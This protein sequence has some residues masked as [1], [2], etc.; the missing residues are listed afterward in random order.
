MPVW[1]RVYFPTLILPVILNTEFTHFFLFKYFWY[2]IIFEQFLSNFSNFW[3]QLPFC[4]TVVS[5]NQNLTCYSCI[6][7]QPMNIFWNNLL[8]FSDNPSQFLVYLLIFH[9]LFKVG[10]RQLRFSPIGPK[11]TIPF[12][13]IILYLMHIN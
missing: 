5:K 12:S 8:L 11:F 13:V 2:F 4:T 10:V 3:A 7:V 9:L 6:M 1:R